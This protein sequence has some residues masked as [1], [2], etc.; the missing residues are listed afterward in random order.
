M[1]EIRELSNGSDERIVRNTCTLVRVSTV[2]ALIVVC[3]IQLW[4]RVQHCPRICHEKRVTFYSIAVSQLRIRL[5]DR[6][7]TGLNG[8]ISCMMQQGP[9]LNHD[10]CSRNKVLR[11]IIDFLNAGVLS[12]GFIARWIF[13]TERTKRGE[14]H[15]H[16]AGIRGWSRAMWKKSTSSKM[17]NIL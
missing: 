15:L 11:H 7:S 1:W 14:M 4:T 5:I 3:G 10:V 13:R 8:S 2:K 12:R 9:W 6:Y 16:F 17:Q